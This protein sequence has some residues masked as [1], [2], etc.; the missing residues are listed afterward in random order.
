MRSWKLRGNAINFVLIN[1]NEQMKQI[2]QRS[3]ALLTQDEGLRSIFALL[4][5]TI[6]VA[7]PLQS[8]GVTN[9]LFARILFSLLGIAGVYVVS[10]KKRAL[11]L[12]GAI[13]FLNLLFLW[14][15]EVNSDRW[16]LPVSLSLTILFEVTLTY[17]VLARTLA[18]GPVNLFRVQGSVVVYL[19]LG[20]TFSSVYSLLYDL[21][22]SS[23]YFTQP[24]DGAEIAQARFIYFSFITLTTIGYG[25]I[26]P[27]HTFSQSAAMMEG[28]IGQLYPAILI[29]RLVSQS[30]TNTQHKK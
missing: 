17:F 11:I 13:V 14:Y 18:P 7:F 29:A 1:P 4:L 10:K 19:L 9:F 27:T 3:V 24:L 21:N 6:F 25:D 2:L 15:R 12:V 16:V 30:L 8:V 20:V 23:F 26:Q 5:L 28:L 22:N